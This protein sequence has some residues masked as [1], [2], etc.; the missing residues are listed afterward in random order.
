MG[1]GKE[2]PEL[3]FVQ[4]LILASAGGNMDGAR[5]IIALDNECAHIARQAREPMMAQIRLAWWRDGL[6]SEEALPAH[7]SPQMDALRALDQFGDIR[8][9]LIAIIDGWEEMILWN[10]DQPEA[11]LEIYASGRGGGFFSALRPDYAGDAALEGAIWSMWDLA[12]HLGDA[13][14]S[15]AAIAY[16]RQ[17]LMKKPAMPGGLPRMLAML[18]G[19]ARHDVKR[20]AAMPMQLTPQLYIRLLRLQIFGR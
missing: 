1:N 6:A 5:Q 14:L 16:G 18:S 3:T 19:A 17:L 12:G 13:E 20:G 9:A 11:M 7:R 8:P 4:R 10:G 2:L 15:A